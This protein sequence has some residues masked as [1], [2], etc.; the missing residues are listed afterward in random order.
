MKHRSDDR[1]L[2]VSELAKF[3]GVAP[4]TIYRWLECGKL[5]RPFEL[6]EAAVRWRLSE[7]EQWLEE[8]RR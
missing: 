2:K 6:G 7:I 3:L 1:L 8:N 5:P 4:S